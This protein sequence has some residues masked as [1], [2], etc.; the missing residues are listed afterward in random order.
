MTQERL[1]NAVF[2][3]P[4]TGLVNRAVFVEELGKRIQEFHRRRCSEPFALLYLDLD[5][6]KIVNDSLGHL[7]GDELLG[8]YL[9]YY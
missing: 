1:R 9:S 7:V 5:R 6:F 2:L 8:W 3:D 4:L